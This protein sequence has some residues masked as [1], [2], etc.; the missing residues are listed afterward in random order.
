MKVLGAS[1]LLWIGGG[2]VGA[3][4][5][6]AAGKCRPIGPAWG[7]LAGA[8]LGAIL[9][10]GI[11]DAILEQEQRTGVFSLMPLAWTSR[12]S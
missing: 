4:G 10:G 12:G 6:Y 7:M 9:L 11:G 5:G 3:F 8:A 2:A 1:K